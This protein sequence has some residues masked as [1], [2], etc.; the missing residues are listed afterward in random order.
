VPATSGD[1]NVPLVVKT[2]RV[3]AVRPCAVYVIVSAVESAVTTAF[4]PIAA[5]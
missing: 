3:S 2:T 4:C 1:G 5:S